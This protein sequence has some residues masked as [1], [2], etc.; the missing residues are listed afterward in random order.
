MPNHYKKIKEKFLKPLVTI[1]ELI[2][3]RNIARWRGVH[4]INIAKY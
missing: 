4:R 3:L 2:V 1:K